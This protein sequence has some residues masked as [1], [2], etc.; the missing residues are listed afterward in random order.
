VRI[1]TSTPVA[2]TASLVEAGCLTMKASPYAALGFPG[3][4][5]SARR[6]YWSAAAVSPNDALQRPALTS[7]IS[8]VLYNGLRM[9]WSNS[10]IDSRAR[11]CV[12]R[13]QPQL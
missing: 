7:A 13:Y 1:T 12:Q 9:A 4:T 8:G 5:A 10:A 2:T 11:S 6:K 3:D